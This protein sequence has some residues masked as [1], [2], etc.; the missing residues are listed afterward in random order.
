MKTR[1]SQPNVF[2]MAAVLSPGVM[3]AGLTLDLLRPILG[4]L[5]FQILR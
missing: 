1:V 4:P 5:G 2:P 3:F